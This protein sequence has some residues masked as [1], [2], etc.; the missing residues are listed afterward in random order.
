M[1]NFQ[2]AQ[3][4]A[5]N[6]FFT[7]TPLTSYSFDEFHIFISFGMILHKYQEIKIPIFKIN[8]TIAH[9]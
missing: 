3:L 6:L 4:L 5:E 8:N 2:L 1:F 9:V 7:S